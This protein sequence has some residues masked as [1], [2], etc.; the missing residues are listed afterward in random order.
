MPPKRKGLPKISTL[1]ST[2]GTSYANESGAW[3]ERSTIK[4]MWSLPTARLGPALD[5][6][7]Q[8][9][10]GSL[11]L[12][13]A[14]KLEST[15]GKRKHG[16]MV[17]GSSEI[18]S[19]SPLDEDVETICSLSKPLSTKGQTTLAFG[20]RTSPSCGEARK[21]PTHIDLRKDPIDPT[22]P[23]WRLSSGETLESEK[24][25]ESSN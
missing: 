22:S 6:Y 23:L 24:Q 21:L 7:F 16:S 1:A 18:G 20:K 5:A 12:D 19:T 9:R 3:V 15:L 4:V 25:G 13:L 14:T 11:A 8:E 17:P 10:T 2:R